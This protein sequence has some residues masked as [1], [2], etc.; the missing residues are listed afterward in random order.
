M[1]TGPMLSYQDVLTRPPSIADAIG[2][3][4]FEQAPLLHL[5]GYSAANK[6][7]LAAKYTVDDS[8]TLKWLE[9][10]LAPTQSALS[11]G[12]NNAVTTIPVTAGTGI[13]FRTGDIVWIDDEALRVTTSAA[14]SF[15]VAARGYGGTSA[16]SHSSAAVVSIETRAMQENAPWQ[17][18]Y[19]TQTVEKWNQSQIISE[20][21]NTSKTE[22]AVS[23]L[24]YDDALDFEVGLKFR[25]EGGGAG[26]LVIKL[27]KIH[28]K[29]LRVARSDTDPGS[30]GGFG[31]FVT[32]HVKSLG[33]A[34]LQKD[35]IHERIRMVDDSGGEITHLVGNSW[36]IEKINAMYPAEE[37]GTREAMGGAVALKTIVT[38][39][40]E[41]A[42]VKDWLCPPGRIDFINENYAGWLP[43]REFER[44]DAQPFSDGWQADV[45]GEYHYFL[46]NEKSHAQLTGISTTS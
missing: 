14:N 10:P 20:M 11:A 17:T 4:G 30:A 21:V 5:L 40:G 29:G 39:A 6:K 45:T 2:M 12:I 13:Y 15:D 46:K 19:R 8:I 35:D 34:S 28:Y 23:K 18:G 43:L 32:T 33:G 44:T 31:T 9:R 16:A 41:V 38:P 1:P 42:L 24:G 22:L 3:L 7:K 25:K 26:E 36:M 27:A 37:R